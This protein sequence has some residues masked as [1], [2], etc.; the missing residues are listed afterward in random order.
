MAL[1]STPNTLFLRFCFKISVNVP[2]TIADAEDENLGSL[3]VLLYMK[4]FQSDLFNVRALL[5][6]GHFLLI[7]RSSSHCLESGKEPHFG[8]C[9]A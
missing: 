9:D 2:L 8:H 5:M 4:N 3:C 1:L 7:A 6:L